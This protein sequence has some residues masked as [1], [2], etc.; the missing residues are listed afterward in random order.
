MLFS[1]M[2]SKDALRDFAEDHRTGC[3]PQ[4]KGTLQSSKD[5]DDLIRFIRPVH[6]FQIESE[7]SSS[8]MGLVYARWLRIMGSL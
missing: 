3:T 8:H 6:G 7:G 4:I 2:R 1:V 5:L